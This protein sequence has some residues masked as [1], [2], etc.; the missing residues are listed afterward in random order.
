MKWKLFAFS[1]SSRG[2]KSS[3]KVLPELISPWAG[4]SLFLCLP[5]THPLSVPS[6][7]I[8]SSYKVISFIGL[9]LEFMTLFN[10]RPSLCSVH[11]N[12]EKD[13]KMIQKPT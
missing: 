4:G 12:V 6:P 1:Y 8:A 7:G 9:G 13:V 3:V 2:Q 10:H 5:I 11:F